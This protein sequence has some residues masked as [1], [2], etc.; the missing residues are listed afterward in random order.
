[1]SERSK[2]EE[3]RTTSSTSRSISSSSLLRFFCIFSLSL[4]APAVVAPP[5]KYSFHKT[6]GKSD[7]SMCSR[8]GSREVIL[9]DDCWG[10]FRSENVSIS[11]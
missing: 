3:G 4:F 11:L 6:G 5:S 9:P 1:M 10:F 2:K 8:T 7:L